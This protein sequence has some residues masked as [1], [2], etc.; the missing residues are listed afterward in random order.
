MGSLAE[1]K[2]AANIGAVWSALGGGKLH[3]NRSQAFWRNGDGYSV[4][5]DA[6]KGVWFDHASGVGGDVVELVRTV[7]QCT[8]ADALKWL[9]D[10]AGISVSSTRRYDEKIDTDWNADLR[11]AIYWRA[12]SRLLCEWELERMSP[13]DPERRGLTRLLSTIRLGDAALVA[14]YRAWRQHDPRMT[15]ALVRC[16]RLHD[17]RLQRRLALWIR[18]TY[19][20]ET[21]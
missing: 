9:A 16:G 6:D 5:I 2:A 4:A 7:Q 19:G 17:A 11:R 14:E 21:T 10:L 15:T 3:G 13:T 20:S 18:R 12:A 8:F 1:I